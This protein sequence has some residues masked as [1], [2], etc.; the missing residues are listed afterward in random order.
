M[1]IKELHHMQGVSGKCI[2]VLCVGVKSA[3]IDVLREL[4]RPLL[5]HAAPRLVQASHL[6]QQVHSMPNV[7]VELFPLNWFSSCRLQDCWQGMGSPGSFGFDYTMASFHHTNKV[8]YVVHAPRFIW[9]RQVQWMRL[10]SNKFIC[11][12]VC[13]LGVIISLGSTLLPVSISGCLTC[14]KRM[15]ES[16]IGLGHYGIDILCMVLV[17][18]FLHTCFFS[19]GDVIT[20]WLYANDID[21]D[22]DDDTSF[23]SS[24]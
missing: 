15:C 2:Q 23:L 6:V 1:L 21:N 7:A 11:Q 12:A 19:D 14:L 24:T 16:N 5:F 22:N 17:M 4:N 10:L 3:W 18:W 20:N 13:N 9:R 8:L